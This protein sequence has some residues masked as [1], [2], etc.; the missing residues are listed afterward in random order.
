LF[1]GLLILA[2]QNINAQG[3]TLDDANALCAGGAGLTFDNGTSGQE[4]Q[5]GIDYGCLV[6][7]PNPAWFFILIDEPGDLDFLIEQVADDGDEID[8][9]FIAWGPFAV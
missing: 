6:S 7:Q 4:A 3:A 5:P 9:D 1:M 2:S 8:V